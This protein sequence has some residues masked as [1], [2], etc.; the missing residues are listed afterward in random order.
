MRRKIIT[1]EQRVA[2]KIASLVS[3]VTIDLEMVGL[4]IARD[5]PNVVYRRLQE[6]TETAEQEKMSE[7]Q[8]ILEL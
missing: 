2:T 1:P 4:S 7:G 3:D 8:G 6:I 5:N